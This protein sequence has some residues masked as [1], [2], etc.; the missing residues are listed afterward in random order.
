MSKE[1]Y[2][3]ILLGNC[4]LHDNI[5]MTNIKSFVSRMV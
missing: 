5:L 1:N 2:N 4:Q 3:G